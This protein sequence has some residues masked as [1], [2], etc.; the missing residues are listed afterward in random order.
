MNQGEDPVAAV[1]R[2]V[3]EEVGLSCLDVRYLYDFP[4]PSGQTSAF[5]VTCAEGEPRLGVDHDLPCD[6]PRMVGLEWVPLP[7]WSGETG[8][9]GVPTLLMATPRSVL[10]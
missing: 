1:R 4:Y 2:E 8:D 5:A 9:P 7:V 3:A 6:C 10:S